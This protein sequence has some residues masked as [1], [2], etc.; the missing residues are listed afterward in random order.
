MRRRDLLIAAASTATARAQAKIKIGFLGG[1]HSHAADK[2]RIARESPD[3]DLAGVWELNEAPS[4]KAAMLNDAT[5]QVI[6]VESDVKSHE[7]L[8]L[9][10]LRAGKHVHVEKPP[11]DNLAGMKPASRIRKNI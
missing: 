3:W 11:S 2:I 5:V 8:A 6:A 4:K 9:E 7:R 10:A 1:T